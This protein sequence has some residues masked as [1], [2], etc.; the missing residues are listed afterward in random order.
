MQGPG[1]AGQSDG[2]CFQPVVNNA[3]GVRHRE[4]G[5]SGP[6]TP[7]SRAAK[8]GGAGAPANMSSRE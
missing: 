7:I 4:G 1:C 2:S 6:K 3:G 5:R 8:A